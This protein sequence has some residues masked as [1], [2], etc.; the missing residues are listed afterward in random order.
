MSRNLGLGRRGKAE[1]HSV[2]EA[3]KIENEDN[4]RGRR[5]RGESGGE[6]QYKWL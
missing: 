2:D 4:G 6:A 3:E 1:I 5:G